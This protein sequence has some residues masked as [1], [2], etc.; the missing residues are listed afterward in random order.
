M[1]KSESNPPYNCGWC[2]SL[3]YNPPSSNPYIPILEFM[4]DKIDELGRNKVWGMES[5]WAFIDLDPSIEAELLVYD[6][7]LNT[8][9]VRS[10]CDVC[11][12]NDEE[13]FDKYYGDE[14]EIG[15]EWDEEI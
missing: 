2:G 7:L 10:I 6:E 14:E 11:L 15:D 1:G 4:E 13:L 5:N 3:T 12:K 9:V 8:Q